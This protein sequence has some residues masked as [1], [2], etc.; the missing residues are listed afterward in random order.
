MPPV[1][2]QDWLSDYSNPASEKNESA[3]LEVETV[4]SN[5]TTLYN[6][7]LYLHMR[8]HRYLL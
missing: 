4:Y 2:C 7:P 5:L 8:L 3:E 1:S 6:L